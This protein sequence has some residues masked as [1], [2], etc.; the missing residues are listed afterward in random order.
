LNLIRS[1][2][3]MKQEE[4]PETIRRV[5]RNSS[6]RDTER[7]SELLDL[8]WTEGLLKERSF[9]RQPGTSVQTHDHTNN[10]EACQC[11][12]C[13]H[14]VELERIDEI[15]QRIPFHWS[16]ISWIHIKFI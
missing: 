7:L 16:F 13:P 11:P 14:K 1:Y 3:G 6:T 8:F 2:Q 4:K 15:L 10:G 12:D 9:T 5:I